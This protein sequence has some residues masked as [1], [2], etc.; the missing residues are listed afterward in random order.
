MAVY[1][2]MDAVTA[3]PGMDARSACPH[4]LI[5]LVEPSETFDVAQWLE[6]A[7]KQEG[8]AVEAG[9]T[10]LYV[11]GTGL[12]LRA[13]TG[14]FA[15]AVGRDE[16]LR[17]RLHRTAQAEG[18]AALHAQLTRADPAEAEVI[19]PNDEK[20]LIR[21]L[22]ILKNSGRLASERRGGWK[23]TAAEHRIV[24]LRWE[25][26]LLA[27]RICTRSRADAERILEE[28]ADVRMTG[29]FGLTA[30]KAAGV[31]EALDVL[32]GT[33]PRE[34]F[35]DALA[36]SVR[37]LARRQ[38]TW[39]RSFP[40]IEWIDRSPGDDATDVGRRAAELLQIP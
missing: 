10:P 24:G 2:R 31:R 23:S 34:D 9:T 4:V 20:R 11:G 6:E 8:L 35:A 14:G 38:R 28:V 27:E 39:W 29:G 30:S 16:D 17:R 1:R 26:D 33:V 7:E 32:D 18:T 12:Y 22:E 21:A 36:Q 25:R 13:L 3:K 5:D 15:D 19:H 40:D 37:R